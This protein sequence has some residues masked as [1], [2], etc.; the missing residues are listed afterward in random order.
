MRYAEGAAPPLCTP[1]L[2]YFI[3]TSQLVLTCSK[4]WS[5]SLPCRPL[6]WASAGVSV[7]AGGGNRVYSP[8]SWVNWEFLFSYHP[9]LTSPCHHV[10][11]RACCDKVHPY[12]AHAYAAPSPLYREITGNI[13]ILHERNLH[14][15]KVTS[16]WQGGLTERLRAVLGSA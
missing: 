9:A 16:A 4:H 2:L 8:R 12:E 5:I 11:M 10:S 3:S 14:L 15:Q 1:P 13:K 6:L 7:H